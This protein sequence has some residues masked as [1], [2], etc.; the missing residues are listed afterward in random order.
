M[1]LL[2]SSTQSPGGERDFS[3]AWGPDDFCMSRRYSPRKCNCQMSIETRIKFRHELS[4][5]LVF[6]SRTRGGERWLHCRFCACE[7]FWN[8]SSRTSVKTFILHA[9]FI[10]YSIT[11]SLF[12][13]LTTALQTCVLRP[14]VTSRDGQLYL[15]W[16]VKTQARGWRTVS[17]LE[18]MAPRKRQ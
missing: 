15:Q 6:L 3:T 9:R 7:L 17:H 10:Q 12:Q 11:G 14:R 18:S 4:I 8:L 16:R 13:A 2:S 5:C 1:N